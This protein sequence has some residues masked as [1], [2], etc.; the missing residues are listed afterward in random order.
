LY[1]KTN[2]AQ[3]LLYHELAP[4]GKRGTI[5]PQW[6]SLV[7]R[8]QDRLWNRIKLETDINQLGFPGRTGNRTPGKDTSH[9]LKSY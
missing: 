3:A 1:L 8:F 4:H 7:F 2:K 5:L 9:S 6:I